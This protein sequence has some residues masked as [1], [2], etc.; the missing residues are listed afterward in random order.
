MISATDRATRLCSGFSEAQQQIKG[1]SQFSI[2]SY[3]SSWDLWWCSPS[4]DKVSALS[5]PEEQGQQGRSALSHLPWALLPARHSHTRGCLPGDT[6]L[7]TAEAHGADRESSLSTELH[8]S[9]WRTQCRHF[10]KTNTL[11]TLTMLWQVCVPLLYMAKLFLKFFWNSK[12]NG[13]CG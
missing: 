9:A 12:N 5:H 7:P 2:R 3:P 13:L 4:R 8:F 11:Q 10:T 6:A 1:L